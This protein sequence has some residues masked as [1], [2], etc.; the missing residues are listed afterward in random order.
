[1]IPKSTPEIAIALG[2]PTQTTRRAL[3]DLAGHKVV[4]RAKGKKADMW[5]LTDEIKICLEKVPKMLPEEDF[6]E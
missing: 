5:D 6:F 4:Q 2:H 3:E 1:V